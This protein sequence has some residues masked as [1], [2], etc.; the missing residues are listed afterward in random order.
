MPEEI[1]NQARV[2]EALRQEI[3]LSR[4]DVE[5]QKTELEGG[6]GELKAGVEK[7]IDYLKRL[8]HGVLITLLVG[9]VVGVIVRASGL[10]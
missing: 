5:N 2:E 9:V 6:I 7:D 3:E 1:P 4:K 10:I 8:L